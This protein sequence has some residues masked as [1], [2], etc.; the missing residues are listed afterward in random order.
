MAKPI[1]L[2]TQNDGEQETFSDLAV[3]DC[4]D[5]ERITRQEDMDAADINKIMARFGVGAEFQ[6][7]MPFNG[8]FDYTVDLQQGLEAVR[9]MENIVANLP[10]E[11]AA[12]YASPGSVL[13]AAHNG[14][15]QKDLSELAAARQ[16]ATR[17][18]ALVEEEALDRM[19]AERADDLEREERIKNRGKPPARARA[20]DLE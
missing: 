20:E 5:D 14:T 1:K 7:R 4:S 16:R 8:E 17:E 2:R 19:R 10:P 18:Q 13:D 9:S 12:K 3:I 11:L 15:L 6:G